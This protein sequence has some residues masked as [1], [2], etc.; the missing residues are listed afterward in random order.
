M[1]DGNHLGD[2]LGESVI[3]ILNVSNHSPSCMS[4]GWG[5]TGG[6][7][8]PGTGV[9][10]RAV[11]GGGHWLC[12]HWDLHSHLGTVGWPTWAQW[13]FVGTQKPRVSCGCLVT[14]LLHSR[15]ARALTPLPCVPTG[16]C[17]AQHVSE[18]K[19]HK[20]TYSVFSTN[21]R[22]EKSYAGGQTPELSS[23]LDC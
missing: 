18:K 19:T 1:A 14:R 3:P 11:Q 2:S 13:F 10:A 12:A 16:P 8:P 17:G 9:Q 5:F 20:M 15:P 7:M 22:G 6:F 21:T 4:A 23:Y